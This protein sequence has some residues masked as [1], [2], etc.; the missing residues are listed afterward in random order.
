LAVNEAALVAD[1]EHW[2]DGDP[3]AIV[4]QMA[5]INAY[6]GEKDP[7]SFYDHDVSVD[8]TGEQAIVHDCFVDDVKILNPIDLTP[9]GDASQTELLD[10]TMTKSSTAAIPWR[11]KEIKVLQTWDGVSHS[12]CKD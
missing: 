6:G 11:I 3:G 10:V 12:D 4:G 1:E 7:S 5:G 2:F 8:L 9:A